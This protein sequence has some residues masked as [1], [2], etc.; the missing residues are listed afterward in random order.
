MIVQRGDDVDTIEGTD[1]VVLAVTAPPPAA[2]VLR[3]LA[4]R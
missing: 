2:R 4:A 1:D 3:R